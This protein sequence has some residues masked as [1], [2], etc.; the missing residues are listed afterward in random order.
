[1]QLLKD[2]EITGYWVH[3]AFFSKMPPNAT[4][5]K[6]LNQILIRHL[7]IKLFSCALLLHAKLEIKDNV[8]TSVIL[9]EII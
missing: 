2:V 8:M 4:D 5:L 9:T 7:K 6:V 3:E 1:M